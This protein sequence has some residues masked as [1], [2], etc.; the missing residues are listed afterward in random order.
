[1]AQ[2]ITVH[3][4][5]MS[6]MDRMANAFAKS[7]LFGVK[8]P[9]Q[10]L[11]LMLVSQ[12]E[13]RHP[14]LA[15]RDYDI[16]QGKPTKKAEAMVRDFQ[17][18]GGKIE[19]HRLDNEMADATFSHELGGSFRCTW[20][21]KRAAEAQLAGKEMWK[22]FPRQMLR[23]RCVSEG[24]RTVLPMATSGMYVPEEQHDIA[25]DQPPMRDVTPPRPVREA[26]QQSTTEPQQNGNGHAEEMRFA[27][28]DADG[29]EH[30]Y[31][32]GSEYLTAFMKL[33]NEA[34][35]KGGFWDT[36]SEHFQ[37]W[38]TRLVQKA[39]RDGATA[40]DKKAAAAFSEVM[41]TVADALTVKAA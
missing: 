23:S 35:D 7:G 9:E 37:G 17:A 13:G 6:D 32:K 8:T 11:A 2:E 36:N 3:Q 21:M 5:S 41:R 10:A 33:F 24:V 12:A 39:D 34:P 19:W 20:D 31:P 27:I 22:K 25:T 28:T 38:H 40:A 18:A 1:M 14:A 30:L 4:M 16:I 26:P 29:D 15:A